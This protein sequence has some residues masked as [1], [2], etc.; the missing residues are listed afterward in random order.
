MITVVG[1]I[2]SFITIVYTAVGMPNQIIKNHKIKSAESLSLFLFVTLFFTFTSW[3][4]YGVLKPDWF[5][6][7]PNALG[8]VCAF[9]IVFQI[10]CYRKK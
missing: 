8:A 3:V 4:V 10:V 2:A 1:Y 9:I 7:I 5:I 6:C